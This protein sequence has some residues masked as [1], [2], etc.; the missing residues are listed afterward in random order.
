[1]SF[2]TEAP[3]ELRNPHIV[4]SLNNGTRVLSTQCAVCVYFRATSSCASPPTHYPYCVNTPNVVQAPKAGV[5]M[6]KTVVDACFILGA[7]LGFGVW[8]WTHYI[9]PM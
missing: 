4:H 7:D 5:L 2:L 8:D 9:T 1:M 6:A 3:A